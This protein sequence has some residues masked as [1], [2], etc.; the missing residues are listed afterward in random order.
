MPKK[1]RC[2]IAVW[3]TPLIIE[4]CVFSHFTCSWFGFTCYSCRALES[5]HIFLL[6]TPHILWLTMEAE[7]WNV[8]FDFPTKLSCRTST[9]PDDDDDERCVVN[10]STSEQ[11]F[12]QLSRVHFLFY[13]GWKQGKKSWANSK[14]SNK[15]ASENKNPPASP[16]SAGFFFLEEKV[17]VLFFRFKTR[18][19]LLSYS[20][21][22]PL[23]LDIILFL[24]LG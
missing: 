6:S 17:K 15:R 23:Q 21:S 7:K 10:G 19:M 9:W 3:R 22:A 12:T 8:C 24:L 14:Q 1:E 13:F 16:W 18:F 2:E 20:P 11:N 5:P 4:R